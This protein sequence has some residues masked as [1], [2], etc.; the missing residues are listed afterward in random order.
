MPHYIP[1]LLPYIG[2]AEI[3]DP[4]ERKTSLQEPREEPAA[5]VS[6]AD[7]TPTEDARVSRS[8]HLR[9][10]FA[11]SVDWNHGE[12]LFHSIEEKIRGALTP[13]YAVYL[14]LRSN[15]AAWDEV[16]RVPPFDHRP[17]RPKVGTEAVVAVTLTAKPRDLDEQRACSDYA[18]ALVWAEMHQVMPAEFADRVATEGL[19]RCRD[20]VRAVRREARAKE[21]ERAQ[22]GTF[23]QGAR[24]SNADRAPG[25]GVSEVMAA[26]DPVP[27]SSS[28]APTQDATTVEADATVPGQPKSDEAV[29]P[30]PST[31][32]S[33]G[34]RPIT[35]DRAMAASVPRD[36]HVQARPRCRIGVIIENQDGGRRSIACRYEPAAWEALRGFL[37]RGPKFVDPAKMLC[38]LAFVVTNKRSPAGRGNRPRPPGKPK[39]PTRPTAINIKKATR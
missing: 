28:G 8:R 3:A 6:Q 30:S 9:H 17:R 4:S 36:S 13:A 29:T 34:E 22:D 32:T 24:E 38:A 37:D 20:Y 11:L 31:A 18:T 14:H 16:A 26:S 39:K 35:V 12:S 33:M 2:A 19:R 23:E 10:D 21:H 15:P 25:D 27:S 7:Q 1:L 5:T